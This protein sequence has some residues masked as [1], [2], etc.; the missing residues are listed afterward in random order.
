MGIFQEG[1]TAILLTLTMETKG[2]GVVYAG[3]ALGLIAT[4]A[5]I[6]GLL[7]PPLGNSLAAIS[8]SYGFLFWAGMVALAMV[9]FL[10]VKETGWRKNVL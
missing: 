9:L 4:F 6:G 5:K 7:G 2:V 8:P 10:F 3:T 1:V